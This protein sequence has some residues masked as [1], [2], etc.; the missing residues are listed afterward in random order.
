[1]E[2]VEKEAELEDTVTG[3]YTFEDI[4]DTSVVE[5]DH[6]DSL[7]L[8]RQGAWGRAMRMFL[9]PRVSSQQS[10]V[11]LEQCLLWSSVFTLEQ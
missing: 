11:T 9:D 6:L 2:E 10:R 1:M 5:R 8:S 7:L 3:Y 4:V